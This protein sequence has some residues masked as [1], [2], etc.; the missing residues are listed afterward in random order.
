VIDTVV[1]DFETAN[2]RRGSPCTF[3]FAQL[4]GMGIVDS[5]SFLIRP[6]EFRFEGF[7]VHLHG[8]TAAMCEDAPD[9]SHAL[10]RIESIVG[11]A[12]VVAHYSPFDIGVIRDACAV[13]G[14]KCP[15][16][17]FACT[18]QMSRILWPGLASYCLPD[19]VA[20]VGG[21][22][23]NHH[24]AEDDALAAA[25]IALSAARLRSCTSVPELVTQLGM[26]P[27]TL[28]G[29]F[30]T[31]PTAP[32]SHRLPRVPSEG[33]AFDPDH[34]FC[35]RNVVFTG[36]LMSMT[37]TVAQQAVVDVGGRAMTSVGKKADFVVVG[38]EF[39]GLLAGHEHS[40]RYE[41]ACCFGSREASWSSSTRRSS[42][43]SCVEVHDASSGR[44][45]G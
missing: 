34:P 8:I 9:W 26:R 3:G 19:M 30:Y 14:S 5:G 7:N 16:L 21:N 35:G 43:P 31:R 6:P 24:Q 37:R 44:C 17:H 41:Q 15:E 38:G 4:D 42:S 23:V 20:V 33:V 28:V 13:T 12:I 2:E 11:G 10:Q 18:R 25:G 29:G 1:I 22:L 39:H 45:V 40:H 32:E 27:G 36:G